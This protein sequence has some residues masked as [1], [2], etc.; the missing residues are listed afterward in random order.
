MI[1]FSYSI[2]FSC[3]RCRVRNARRKIDFEDDEERRIKE[4][5]E[6]LLNL[7]GIATFKRWA[8]VFFLIVFYLLRLV[9]FRY[10]YMFHRQ[11]SW[12]SFVNL[13][14]VGQSLTWLSECFDYLVYIWLC[15]L[16]DV[17]VIGWMCILIFH[18]AM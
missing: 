1:W 11:S 5:A 12:H 17:A 3:C 7:A 2:F 4:G 15:Y 8:G 18:W 6:T 9:S 16:I 14:V 10:I 13:I